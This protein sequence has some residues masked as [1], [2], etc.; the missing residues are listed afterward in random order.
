MIVV[1]VLQ[2]NR[3]GDD[4]QSSAENQCLLT[5]WHRGHSTVLSIHARFRAVIAVYFAL[6]LVALLRGAAILAQALGNCFENVLLIRTLNFGNDSK[7]SLLIFRAI[8]YDAACDIVV[9]VLVNTEGMV[10]GLQKIEV[11]VNAVLKTA[12]PYE[13]GFGEL[14]VAEVHVV[15]TMVSVIMAL[16]AISVVVTVVI[17]VFVVAGDYGL[18]LRRKLSMNFGRQKRCSEKK[19]C[20]RLHVDGLEVRLAL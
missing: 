8:V 7:S 18:A 13:T 11:F 2:E 19:S 5:Q 6:H 20:F 1:L 12:W 15:V 16:L 10:D 17:F 9:E 4:H 14:E 3:Q